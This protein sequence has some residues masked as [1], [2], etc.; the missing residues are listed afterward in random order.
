MII[1]KKS[2]SDEHRLVDAICQ[3][4]FHRIACEFELNPDGRCLF[5]I[6]EDL[7]GVNSKARIDSLEAYTI[8]KDV[9]KKMVNSHSSR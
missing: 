6:N 9:I 3:K 7:V 8:D 2:K 4:C 1:T 5:Y